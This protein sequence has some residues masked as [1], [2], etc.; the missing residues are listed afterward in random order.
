MTATDTPVDRRIVVSFAN[1]FK[2]RGCWD[3]HRAEETHMIG[4]FQ[5]CG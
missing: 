5:S 3:L 1:A 2:E 4:S